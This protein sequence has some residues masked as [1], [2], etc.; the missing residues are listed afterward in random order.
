MGIISRRS[1]HWVGTRYIKR[2]IDQFGNVANEVETE[3]F[4]IEKLA[5]EIN[6]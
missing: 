6:I 1:R 2:G 4:L 3:F 5:L